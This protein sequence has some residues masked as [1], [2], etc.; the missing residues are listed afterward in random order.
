[1]NAIVNEKLVAIVMISSL[2]G[3]IMMSKL[4]DS[5]DDIETVVKHL[6]NWIVADVLL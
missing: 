2:E 5:N 3:A 6:K 4:Q 1:V